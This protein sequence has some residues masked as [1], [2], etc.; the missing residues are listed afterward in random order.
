MADNSID[1][2]ALRVGDTLPPFVRTTH[3]EEWNRYAAVNDEFVPIHM[4]DE[5]GQ[6]AGNESG[7]FG[8]GNL[9]RA[10]LLNMIHAWAGDDAEVRRLT[11]R[12][13]R[14]NQKNDELRTFGRITGTEI[15]DGVPLVHLEVDVLDADGNS[16]T[17]GSATV[18]LSGGALGG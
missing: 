15:V 2:T 7:A 14:V 9:R 4:D 16:T 10:Y 18:A 3:F 6:A 5:A 8:M 13:V 12:Y 1:L 17:P 11:I